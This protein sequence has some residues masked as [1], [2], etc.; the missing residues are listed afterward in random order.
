[1]SNS[2]YLWEKL[3]KDLKKTLSSEALENWFQTSYF[4]GKNSV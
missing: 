3:I 1:M 4:G 2:N